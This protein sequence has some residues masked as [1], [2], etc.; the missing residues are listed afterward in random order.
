[1][2]DGLRAPEITTDDMFIRKFMYGTWHG[3]FV[4]E[5]IIKRRHNIIIVA[6]IIQ[7]SVVPRKLY[8]L[9]GYTEELL[10]NFL[11]C[12]VKVEVQSVA[13]KKDVVFKYI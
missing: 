13:D 1:M 3:I 6:G 9:I 8:F 4:S 12:P 7:Q 5:V 11:K 10:S 2:L